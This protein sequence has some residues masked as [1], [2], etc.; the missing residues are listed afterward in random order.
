[1]PTE[2]LYVR[3]R[4]IGRALLKARKRSKKSM[5]E[6]AEHIGTSRQRYAGFETGTVFIG[7]VELEAL[8]RY[9]D[10]P[11]IEVWPR[12]MLSQVQV[13]EVTLQARP[14]ETLRI[15]V[16]VGGPAAE[17]ITGA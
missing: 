8:M 10:I 2:D 5:R 17:D 6:C 11:P 12:D 3:S 4:E 9:L 14:G 16:N 13:S 7:A 1:M 15:V